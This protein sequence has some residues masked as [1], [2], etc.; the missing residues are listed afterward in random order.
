MAGIGSLGCQTRTRSVRQRGVEIRS[1]PDLALVRQ[2]PLKLIPRAVQTSRDGK[3]LLVGTGDT[4]GVGT[5]Q[6]FD[7]DTLQAVTPEIRFRGMVERVQFLEEDRRILTVSLDGVVRLWQS[8]TGQPSGPEIRVGRRI[9]AL[10]VH[11]DESWIATGTG[12]NNIR[13]VEAQYVRFWD[14]RTGE[15]ISPPIAHGNRVLHLAFSPA[16]SRLSSTSRDFHLR[17]WKLPHEVRPFE[18]LRAVVQVTTGA[19]LDAADNVTPLDGES[20]RKMWT[21]LR[22][23]YEDDFTAT[24]DEERDWRRHQSEIAQSQKDQGA[25]VDYLTS[26]IELDGSDPE[27]YLRRVRLNAQL[28]RWDSV[29]ADVQTLTILQSRTGGELAELAELV[30]SLRHVPTTLEAYVMGIATKGVEQAPEDPG[31]LIAR[32]HIHAQRGRW[33]EAS[34][35]LARAV[36]LDSG[37]FR[38]WYELALTQLC[39]ADEA[40]FAETCRR[41]RHAIPASNTPLI[42]NFVAWTA[43]LNERGADD[44]SDVIARAQWALDR[45]P[46]NDGYLTSTGAVLYREGRLDEALRH[47]SEANRLLNEPSARKASSPAYTWLF[48][49]MTYQQLGATDEARVWFDK[50]QQWKESQAAEAAVG[51]EFVAAWNREATLQLLCSEAERLFNTNLSSCSDPQVWQ[52]RAK[53]REMQGDVTGAEDAWL[54]V[55]KW[56]GDN[57]LPWI[58]RG[59]WY[60]AHGQ[61]EKADADFAKGAS[62]TPNELNKFLEAGW[63]VV[64][65]YPA[66]LKE[67]CPPEVDPDPSRPVHVIDPQTGL[68]DQPVKWQ[69]VPTTQWGRVDLTNFPGRKDIASVYALSHVYSPE[70]RTV[71]LMIH[72]SRPLRLWVNGEFIEDYVPGEYPAQPYYEQFH[73]VPIVLHPGRNTILVKATTPDFYVRVGDTPRDRSILLAEQQRFAEAAQAFGQLPA[74]D[75]LDLSVLPYLLPNVLALEGDHER[76]ERLCAAVTAGSE[77]RHASTKI[78]VAYFC[79][80]TPNPVF[81]AHAEQL[82]S[83]A[84]EYA[85]ANREPWAL[86]WAA[87]VNYRANHRERA[88]SLL[89][90]AKWN[91][92]DRLLRALLAHHAGDAAAAQQFLDEGLAVATAYVESS[93]QHDRAD[94]DAQPFVW[95]YDW[96]T[97]LTLLTEAEQTIRGETTQSNGVKQR[98]EAMMAQKWAE[99]PETAAFDH[100]ML[101][102]SRD[103]AQQVKYGQ[104]YLARG[105]RLAELG[106]FGEA[107]VDF[108]Q[109]VELAPTDPDVLTQ[110]ALFF[111]ERD[112]PQRAAADFDAALTLIEKQNPPRWLWG[113]TI[114]AEVAGRESVYDALQAL[115][116]TDGQLL[117]IRIISRLRNGERES[118]AAPCRQLE[119]FGFQPYLAAVHLLRGD[120]VEFERLRATDAGDA[121]HRTLLWGLAPTD[122]TIVPR[123]LAAAEELG[124]QGPDDRWQRRWIGLAQL[125]A[126]RLDEAK[127]TLLGCLDSQSAWQVDSIVWPLLA[128]TCH[129]LGETA[130]SQRW[131]QKS[132]IWLRTL[133]RLP[134]AA[135]SGAVVRGFSCEEWLMACVFH[136]E[137]KALIEGA[138][139]PTRPLPASAPE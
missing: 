94:F 71:L 61:Q 60:A 82:V 64:G 72:K 126:G 139:D 56:A 113:R 116:P 6:V 80:Q 130:E 50:A 19:T 48:L 133:E 53:W 77:S 14:L 120:R 118:L 87:L 32:S 98:Y 111:A 74:A 43:A 15:P 134:P 42:E 100:V 138:A 106:R 105:K 51:D 20:F 103:G 112:D 35:D 34:R 41:M 119:Q 11:P 115:R 101:F 104:P 21:S 122:E 57:P 13:G 4:F 125:R 65:P 63:W 33:S 88:S 93:Q 91:S 76:Y 137:A 55:T 95:W 1:L 26:L 75:Q 27:L 24:P 78:A 9:T 28:G 8:D 17:V 67:F 31:T 12:T 16:G 47:L 30:A 7:L 81:D 83:Y 18:D 5:A 85:A 92:Q 121:Y 127:A 109:A 124:R 136:R 131:W 62:L 49:A 70:E 117:S 86:F 2:M 97:F 73:R 58:H 66:E 52:A 40:A 96:A 129:Q 68:S 37:N 54:Q 45:L 38:T 132:E 107:E 36:E 29:P 110:R 46:F 128:I 135:W 22:E 114:D 102:A 10:A 79:A 44:W 108:S 59:R 3:R 123:L 90:D 84:E 99:S 89:D 39:S 25:A 69:S 23:R